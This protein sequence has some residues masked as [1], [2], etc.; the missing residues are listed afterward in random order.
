MLSLIVASLVIATLVMISNY[1]FRPGLELDLKNKILSKQYSHQLLNPVINVEGRN[2]ILK[3]IARNKVE[4]AKIEA[5]ILS[6]SGINDLD[7]RL[8]IQ[9]QSDQKPIN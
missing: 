9:N 4:A 3:G 7:S 1:F 2:V 8:L 6:V 5:E